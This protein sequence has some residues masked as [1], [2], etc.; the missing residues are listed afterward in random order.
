MGHLAFLAPVG[1]FAGLSDTVRHEI[2]NRFPSVSIAEVESAAERFSLELQASKP[3][4]SLDETRDEL[5]SFG[6]E[7]ARFHGALD[8]VRNHWLRQ[9]IG[10]ASRH[11]GGKNEIEHLEH[12]LNNLGSAIRRTSRALPCER[13]Q[14]ASR[15]LIAT[16]AGLMK[17]GTEPVR[18]PDPLLSLVDLIFEDLMVGGDAASAVREWRQN[19]RANIDQEWAGLLLDLVS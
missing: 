5:N 3:K 19:Q 17:H 10:E 12:A 11:I 14:I 9:A 13:S 18:G 1:P 4:S 2:A 15:R 6:K 16:L 8:R 7:V